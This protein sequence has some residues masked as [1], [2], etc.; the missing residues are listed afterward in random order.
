MKLKN[1]EFIGGL[2]YVYIAVR[3]AKSGYHWYRRYR[4]ATKL[5]GKK[6]KM[7]KNEKVP[8]ILPDFGWGEG[9][10]VTLYILV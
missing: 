8:C 10:M 9:G 6:E 5:K 3:D 7:G 2:L 4:E 1:C